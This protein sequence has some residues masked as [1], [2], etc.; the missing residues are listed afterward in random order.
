MHRGLMW[1]VAVTVIA[2]V[3]FFNQDIYDIDSTTVTITPNSATLSA[4][5]VTCLVKVNDT[6]SLPTI[7]TGNVTWNNSNSSGTFTP[8]LCILSSGSCTTSYT[9]AASFH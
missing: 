8:A 5:S 2:L 9:P 4:G 7:P 1:A 6:S 3:G